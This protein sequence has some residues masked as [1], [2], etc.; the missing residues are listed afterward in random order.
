MPIK[1]DLWYD[2]GNFFNSDVLPVPKNSL[3]DELSRAGQSAF[4][5]LDD[6]E[7]CKLLSTD[8][9]IDITAEPSLLPGT[10]SY[11]TTALDDDLLDIIAPQMLHK[12]SSMGSRP[13]DGK[14]KRDFK[15]GGQLS[16]I[17][18]ED[19]SQENGPLTLLDIIP[20]LA[21]AHSLSTGSLAADESS[22]LKSIFAKAVEIPSQPPQSH[23]HSDSSSKH[24]T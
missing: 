14:L 1:I 12:P 22:L 16:P 24:R 15:F 13:S 8:F 11:T 9:P 3:H 2:F 17:A 21:V 5:L 19:D 18:M 6:Y 10:D 7:S 4:S 23:L 20:P